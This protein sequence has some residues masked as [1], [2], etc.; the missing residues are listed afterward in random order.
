MVKWCPK[1]TITWKKYVRYFGREKQEDAAKVVADKEVSVTQ[2]IEKAK[3]EINKIK[4]VYD[5]KLNNERLPF[6]KKTSPSYG[7]FSDHG[8]SV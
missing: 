3:T 2:A 6:D 1:E 5:K 7:R 4:E 8:F